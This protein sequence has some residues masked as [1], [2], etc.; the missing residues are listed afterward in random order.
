MRGPALAKSR[1][2][3][4][5]TDRFHQ[6]ITIEVEQL[7]QVQVVAAGTSGLQAVPGQ[8]SVFSNLGTKHGNAP[9]QYSIDCLEQRWQVMLG[10]SNSSLDFD[11]NILEY[12]PMS[13]RVYVPL[14]ANGLPAAGDTRTRLPA[15]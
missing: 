8:S 15:T 7:D 14:V 11:H 10:T 12:L 5:P 3:T 1:P 6:H 2:D 4:V 13:V 9:A